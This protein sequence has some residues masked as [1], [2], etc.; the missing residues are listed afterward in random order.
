MWSALSHLGLYFFWRALLGQKLRHASVI[1]VKATHASVWL[2]LFL[3]ILI[4]LQLPINNVSHT[5]Q[6][7]RA[8]LRQPTIHFPIG[9]QVG[10]SI[11][12]G[13]CVVCTEVMTRE[14]SIEVPCCHQAVHVTR[15]FFLLVASCST[16]SVSNLFHG[17]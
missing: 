9:P 14:N 4:P 8:L 5:M 6:K 3:S 1:H 16:F 7:F 2:F 17:A 11:G 13:S 15:S 12:L 10:A